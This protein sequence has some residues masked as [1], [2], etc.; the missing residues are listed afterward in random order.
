METVSKSPKL[1]MSVSL[2]PH[3]KWRV[4]KPT[5]E[6]LLSRLNELRY[7]NMSRTVFGTY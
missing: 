1:V 3:L 2:F 6:G 4:I 7:G 5:S